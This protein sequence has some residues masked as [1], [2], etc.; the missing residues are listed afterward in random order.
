[1][2]HLPLPVDYIYPLIEV[3]YLCIEPHDTTIPFLEYPRR[4]GRAWML[5]RA[6]NAYH[7]A[8]FPTPT[9]DLESFFQTW[10]RFSLLPELL[11]E[12]FYHE[13]FVSKPGRDGSLVVSTKELLSL[14]E[15][16]FQYVRKLSKSTQKEVCIH[17]VQCIELTTTVEPSPSGRTK[18]RHSMRI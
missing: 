16:R 13:R 2:D 14:T 7:E 15:Q 17:A 8:L 11:A 5:R 3:P 4:K 10:L 18:K 1:M 6:S 9:C 12:L